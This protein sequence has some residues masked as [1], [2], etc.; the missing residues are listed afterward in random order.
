MLEIGIKGEASALCCEKNTAKTMGSGDLEVFATPSMIAIM[1]MA[2]S[3]SVIRFLEDGQTT[4]GTALNIS[5]VAATPLEMAVR[6]ESELTE[7]D[8]RKLSF[9]VIAFDECGKIGEG[10]HERFIIDSEKFMQKTIEK[11]NN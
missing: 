11:L 4:V 8:G 5:H 7:I 1:E 2:A 3:R 9:S 6:C 10:T